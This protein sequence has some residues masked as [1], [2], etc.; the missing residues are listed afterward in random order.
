MK[1]KVMPRQTLADMAV[2]VYGDIRAIVT[3]ADAN[4]LPL[5]HD[6]PAGTMLEC[7][8]TVFDKY[9]QEYVRDQKISPATA[10][11]DNL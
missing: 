6:V 5:T 3:L 10:T 2:Q 9:M 7:P 11:E 4:N 8:E 1:T